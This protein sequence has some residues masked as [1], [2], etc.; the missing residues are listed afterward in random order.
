MDGIE[1]GKPGRDGPATG[2]FGLMK[3]DMP[4]SPAHS[5]D[6]KGKDR[7]RAAVKESETTL[8]NVILLLKSWTSRLGRRNSPTR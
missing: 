6:R 4:S 7:G 1:K 8:K 3:V 2:V 5:V